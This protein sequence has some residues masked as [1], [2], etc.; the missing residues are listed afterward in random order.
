MKI[1]KIDRRIGILGIIRFLAVFLR[2]IFFIEE[3]IMVVFLIGLLFSFY[4][5]AFSLPKLV[6]QAQNSIYKI[7][8][9]ESNGT[10]FFIA[11]R[12]FV[13]NCHG[14]AGLLS[15]NLEDINFYQEDQLS[16]IKIKRMVS[17]SC[18]FD[19][20][21]FETDQAVSSHISIAENVAIHS[22]SLFFMGY[23][24][25]VFT[26]FRQTGSYIQ[27]WTPHT[28]SFM[29]SV[30][31]FDSIEGAS[32]SPVL[33][34]DGKATGVIFQNNKNMYF[35]I[36]ADKIQKL[37]DGQIGTQC[38]LFNN[39]KNCLENELQSIEQKL[40]QGDQSALTVGRGIVHLLRTQQIHRTHYSKEKKDEQIKALQEQEFLW[41]QQA[42]QLGFAQVQYTL[43]FLYKDKNDLERFIYWL[44]KS[45]DQYFVPAQFALFLAYE[46]GTG[47]EQ[48][49]QKAFDL[50]IQLAF[51]DY[52][53][54]Q[55]ILS[56]W[57]EEGHTIERSLEWALY[58]RRKSAEEGLKYAQYRFA[59]N[60][61]YGEGV[62]QDSGKA[63]DWMYR[64]AQ[65]GHLEAQYML[66]AFYHNGE[67]TEADNKQ[68]FYWV[69]QAA[70][71]GDKEAQ[72]RTAQMY[73]KGQGVTENRD[74]ALYWFEQAAIQGHAESQFQTAY[75]MYRDEKTKALHSRQIIYWLE[76]A[77]EQGHSS[78]Q[79]ILESAEWK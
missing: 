60:Y 26:K 41:I 20:A 57:Y 6:Q 45:A 24:D 74:F 67:G 65:Q 28:F 9:S 39:E 12:L 54:A 43:A 37:V 31:K 4:S 36:N 34:R 53:P 14:L 25:G 8:N 10:G 51:Q 17:L 18:L 62:P 77:A 32:G 48:D 23:P 21:L 19:L 58:W 16:S 61:L 56:I 29:G 63:F 15:G 30:S 11:P 22:D 72:Y 13:T 78:A 75:L 44:K 3:K 40:Q 46:E 69:F 68:A 38:S 52:M 79:S 70:Q 47:V 5:F 50:L 1:D 66:A 49:S 42:A 2:C 64:S 73:L 71:K 59:L 33:N 7:E 76:Q 35:A 55:L 27:R